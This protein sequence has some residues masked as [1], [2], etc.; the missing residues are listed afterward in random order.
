MRAGQQYVRKI[1]E[2]GTPGARQNDG[3]NIMARMHLDP[4]VKIYWLFSVIGFLAIIWMISLVGITYID[5]DQTIFGMHPP[6]FAIMSA[7]GLTVFILLP[8]Y[9]YCMMEYNAYTYE[10]TEQSV[11]VRSGI[12]TTNEAVI[13]YSHIS[14]IDSERSVMERLLG[15]SSVEIATPGP[16]DLEVN[17]VIPGIP[18]SFSFAAEIEKWKSRAQRAPSEQAAGAQTVDNKALLKLVGEMHSLNENMSRLLRE[19]RAPPR[20]K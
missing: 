1:R 6:V 14:K 18:S 8:L 4:K 3:G 13:P 19:I 11:V 9:F 7:L 5:E 16:K 12:F 17:H 15:L 2:A 10:F 20:K